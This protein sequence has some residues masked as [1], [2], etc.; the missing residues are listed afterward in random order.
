MRRLSLLILL[1]LLPGVCWSKNLTQ[2]IITGI[3]AVASADYGKAHPD[4]YI[5][6]DPPYVFELDDLN[7]VAGL[8]IGNGT[9]LGLTDAYGLRIML[10]KELDMTQAWGQ[11]TLYHEL[12][13]YL[14]I[15]DKG[16]TDQCEESK[17][18]ETEAYTMEGQWFRRH[19]EELLFYKTMRSLQWWLLNMVCS[20]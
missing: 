2:E 6:P 15:H 20:T 16:S 9:I 18:R 13:H 17:A 8:D 10:N 5:P 14:Q 1:L 19:G 11:G 7:Q 12:I 4:A 3:Y